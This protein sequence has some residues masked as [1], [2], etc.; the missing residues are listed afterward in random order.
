MQATGVLTLYSATVHPGDRKLVLDRGDA[1][2]EAIAVKSSA[3]VTTTLIPASTK[4]QQKLVL[5]ATALSW[6]MSSFSL[7]ATIVTNSTAPGQSIFFKGPS[8]HTHVPDDKN[9]YIVS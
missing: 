4:Q 5:P 9:L 2:R 3:A 7:A 6:G 1:V 8:S